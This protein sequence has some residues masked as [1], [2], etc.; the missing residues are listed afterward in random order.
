M[1]DAGT[2]RGVAVK[3]LSDVDE[4][5]TANFVQEATFMMNLDHQCIVQLI[6][7]TSKCTFFITKPD[8]KL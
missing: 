6:G 4:E 5:Q 7:T 2:V 1:N 3:V 8:I